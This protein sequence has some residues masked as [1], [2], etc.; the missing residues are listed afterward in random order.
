MSGNLNHCEVLLSFKKSVK[1]AIWRSK[2]CSALLYQKT[3][4]SKFKIITYLQAFDDPYQFS[5]LLLKKSES[6]KT[7]MYRKRNVCII[8]S[9][10]FF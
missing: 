7:D 1:S 9:F 2:D 10:H 3:V 5:S 4:T 6:M 8:I